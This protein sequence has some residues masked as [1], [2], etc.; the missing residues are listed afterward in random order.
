MKPIYIK[1][2]CLCYILVGALY[3]A[4]NSKAQQQVQKLEEPPLADLGLGAYITGLYHIQI[5]EHNGQYLYEEGGVLKAG[6]F[7]PNASDNLINNT[8]FYFWIVENAY[9]GTFQLFSARDKQGNDAEKKP[10]EIKNEGTT[11]NT[12]FAVHNNTV[13]ASHLLLRMYNTNGL[14]SDAE[15][16]YVAKAHIITKP[17]KSNFGNSICKCNV[18]AV[19]NKSKFKIINAQGNGAYRPITFEAVKTYDYDLTQ[20]TIDIPSQGKTTINQPLVTNKPNNAKRYDTIRNF[21]SSKFFVKGF[22]G[23][24]FEVSIRPDTEGKIGFIHY[25]YHD[26]QKDI[27]AMATPQAGL[28]IDNGKV[29]LFHNGL[30]GNQELPGDGNTKIVQEIELA[31]FDIATDSVRFGFHNQDSLVAKIIRAQQ[32]HSTFYLPSFAPAEFFFNQSISKSARMLVQLKKGEVKIGYNANNGVIHLPNDQGAQTAGDLYSTNPYVPYHPNNADLANTFDWQQT[33]WNYKY[34]NDN[35]EHKFSPFYDFSSNVTFNGIRLQYDNNNKYAAGEDFSP[36]EGWELVKAKL[37]YNADGTKVNFD[38]TYPYVILYNRIAGV[39]RVIVLIRDQGGQAQQLNLAL[40]VNAGRLTGENAMYQPKLWG[41]LQ[42]FKAW[43]Q[44]QLSKYSRSTEL[45]PN[46]NKNWYH[47]DFTMEYD[48]CISFFES[49]IQ[50]YVTKQTQGKIEMAGR[51]E[52]GAIPGGTYAYDQWKQHRGDFLSGVMDNSYGDLANTLGDITFNQYDQFDLEQFS[53]NIDGYLEG[54]PIPEWKKA[55]ARLEWEANEEISNIEIKEGRAKIVSGSAQVVSGA[56]GVGGAF[57]DAATF[58]TFSKVTSGISTMAQGASQ[59]YQGN[60]GIKK[61]KA[62]SKIANSKKLYYKHIKDKTKEKDQNISLK[63]PPPRPQVVFGEL[64]LKGTLSITTTLLQGE[65]V[66]TPGSKDAEKAPQWSQS[67]APAPLYN[68]PMGK[69]A[70]LNTPE[71]GISIVSNT[72][73]GEEN[74]YRAYLRTKNKPY[75][76]HN[77]KV[78]GKIDDMISIGFF[79]ET[80]KTDKYIRKGF[81]KGGYTN[82]FGADNSALPGELDITDLIEWDVIIDNLKEV[83][84]N[85]QFTDA[86]IKTKL[87]EWIKVSYEVWSLTMTNVKARNLTRVFANGNNYY[88][89]DCMVAYKNDNSITSLSAL[90]AAAKQQAL[91]D[92]TIKDYNFSDINSGNRLWGTNYNIYN[93]DTNGF[94]TLMQSY[95]N[96]LGV[97]SKSAP[98]EQAVEAKEEE[99]L[100]E[101]EFVVYPNPSPDVVNF[102]LRTAIEGE[103][104]IALYDQSG[105]E[106]IRTTELLNGRDVLVGNIDIQV[107]PAGIYILKVVLANGQEII[108]RVVK[109]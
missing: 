5:D 37:G 91:V 35:E 70:L 95:C 58:G 67:Q 104:A 28:R 26:Y 3:N 30:S 88:S 84:P 7:T 64:A 11:G 59:I 20:P 34:G 60:L 87:E 6:S 56:L 39:L 22:G 47:A 46:S 78:L 66:T 109:N 25:L 108:K 75:I 41:S 71:F 62:R 61:G 4:P 24:D 18:L 49:H 19:D 15:I 80:R 16:Q 27:F 99:I 69:F 44:T 32:V 74:R 23:N 2:L 90:A 85:G 36:E 98:I 51:M 29:Y 55:A 48:P 42:Q 106:L 68:L 38:N 1:F 43:D 45:F 17:L 57:I 52:G 73:F 82:L 33:K 79:V 72:S 54:K 89:G 92:N 10:L 63:M 12:K 107:L 8:K 102:N 100:I 93:S 50:I 31:G 13:A 105:R 9:T 14:R 21:L 94:G 65:Y 97:T 81:G 40:G 77:N 103:A 53:D 83:D 86:Q 101:E 96:S 76:A